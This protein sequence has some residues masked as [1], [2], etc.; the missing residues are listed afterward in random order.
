MGVSLSDSFDS[1]IINCVGIRYDRCVQWKLPWLQWAIKQRRTTPTKLLFLALSM[2]TVVCMPQSDK[3][4]KK[5]E[6]AADMQHEL[7]VFYALQ[8]ASVPVPDIIFTV[9][10]DVQGVWFSKAHVTLDSK[11]FIAS[12]DDQQVLHAALQMISIRAFLHRANLVSGEFAPRHFG[13]RGNCVQLLTASNVSAAH[14]TSMTKPT[15]NAGFKASCLYEEDAIYERSAHV[16]D[17]AVAAIIYQM[18]SIRQSP[19]W[20]RASDASRRCFWELIKH[21]DVQRVNDFM[22]LRV[23]SKKMALFIAKGLQKE[24]CVSVYSCAKDCYV[25]WSD[26]T[27][28][29]DESAEWEDEPPVYQVENE[30]N[31]DMDGF[32]A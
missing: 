17:F 32:F 8:Q 5:Y 3:V 10:M 4:F 19:P 26:P 20:R 9:D 31:V 30:Q 6:C 29:C 14:A 28:G 13:M 18:L 22:C 7:N 2:P 21:D 24:R 11:R 16:D 1:Q 25:S 15:I 12:L 23:D 27:R